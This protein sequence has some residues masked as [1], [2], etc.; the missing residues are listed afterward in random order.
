MG[1]KKEFQMESM[2]DLENG[3]VLEDFWKKRNGKEKGMGMGFGIFEWG[4]D[5]KWRE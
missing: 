5:L 1:E 4:F 3:C 2:K